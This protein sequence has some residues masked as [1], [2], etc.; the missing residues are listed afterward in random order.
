MVNFY[1]NGV[2]Y[3]REDLINIKHAYAITIHKSQGSEFD[4]VIMPITMNYGRM[5]YNKLIYTGASRAKKSLTMLGNPQAFYM[6]VNNDYSLNR[7][8]DL[9]EKILNK[10]K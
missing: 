8:T 4:H 10:L 6:G 9:V 2:F 1:G 7:K 3:K 5:L